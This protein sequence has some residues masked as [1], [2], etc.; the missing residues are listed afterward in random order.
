MSS[1]PANRYERLLCEF[2][3]Y[4][5]RCVARPDR[6]FFIGYARAAQGPTLE[7]GCGTG[8]ILIPTAAAGCTVVGLDLSRPMLKKCREK[9]RR[10]PKRVRQ[11]ARLVLGNMAAFNLDQTFGLVTIP[12]RGFQH[13]LTRREQ[14]SC[15]RCVNR[16]LFPKG[17][18]ILDLFPIS[19][20]VMGD[21]R[22]LQEEEVSP[23]VKVADGRRIRMTMRASAFHPRQHFNDYETIFY[24]RHLGGRKQRVVQKLPLRYLFRA[25]AEQLLRRCGFRMASVFGSFEKEQPKKNSR[26]MLI[27]AEKVR[28]CAG[29]TSNRMKRKRRRAAS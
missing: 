4:I 8:R 9:L 5:P 15:L 18:L 3:D 14:L 28:E 22:A 23:E 27:I 12:Y 6:K 16:H 25:E 19:P 20:A 29:R 7:L 26:H 21:P 1:S 17:K 10:Q 13:L 24:V 2:Y 11:R